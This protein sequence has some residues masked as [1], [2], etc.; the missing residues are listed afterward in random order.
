MKY[1]LSLLVI[2]LPVFVVWAE[3]DGPDYYRITGAISA[4]M[5]EDKS[6]QTKLVLLVPPGTDGIQNLGCE[7]A[8]SLA[9]WQ[10]MS[11]QARQAAKQLTWCKVSV[12]GHQGWIQTQ[13]LAEGSAITKQPTFDCTTPRPHEIEILICGDLVLIELDQTLAQVFQAAKSQASKLENNAQ[14]AV[15][16]LTAEQRGWIKDRNECWKDQQDKKAC[17]MAAYQQRIAYLESKWGQQQ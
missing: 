9:D 15:K 5:F 4:Q 3:A 12:N 17:A 7:G 16:S 10:A 13:F 8:P 6:Q 1:L 2:L 14:D 11:E